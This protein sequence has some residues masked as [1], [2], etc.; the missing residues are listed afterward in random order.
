MVLLFLA[1][2]H[3]FLDHVQADA[4]LVLQRPNNAP[5]LQKQLRLDQA[6]ERVARIPFL[7][8]RHRHQSIELLGRLVLRRQ[9]TNHVLLYELF[10]AVLSVNLN[11]LHLA[12]QPLLLQLFNFGLP[13]IFCLLALGLI[14]TLI[15]TST[16]PFTP[17]LLNV[18]FRNLSP[19]L[20]FNFFPLLLF[21][22]VDSVV[23]IRHK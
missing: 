19:K 5:G 9:L 16:S 20:L 1:M 3:Q 17:S 21:K 23:C 11:T 18:G 14:P 13:D 22:L 8:D 12:V 7:T 4:R 2:L 6:L 10:V 15:N